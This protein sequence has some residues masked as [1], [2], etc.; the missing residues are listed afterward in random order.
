MLNDLYNVLCIKIFLTHVL[1]SPVKRILKSVDTAVFS[2]E[3]NI[4]PDLINIQRHSKL[5]KLHSKGVKITRTNT[6]VADF[7][8]H[9]CLNVQIN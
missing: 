8:F 6:I 7:S 3:N 1:K 4:K 5:N 9:Y 2:I